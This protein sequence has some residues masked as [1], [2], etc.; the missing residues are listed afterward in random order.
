M[1]GV[2]SLGV[3]NSEFLKNRLGVKGEE[4]RPAGMILSYPVI[5]SG[6][7]AHHDSFLNLLGEEYETKKEEV[8][9]EKCVTEETVP[10]FLWHTAEDEL[11]PVENSLLFFAALKRAGVSV[12]LHIFPR[13]RHGLSLANEE[14]RD[15]Q[16]GL[17]QKECECWI[18][19]AETWIHQL[20]GDKS[21]G[22]PK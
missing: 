11:V 18:R 9:L 21:L 4:L 16:E 14:S 1:D 8:S 3:K 20:F 10:A 19:L 7:F 22:S 6:E 17:M 5:T 2:S 15:V 12:E 13:G